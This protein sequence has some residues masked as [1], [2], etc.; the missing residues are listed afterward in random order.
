M[1]FGN[2]KEVECELDSIESIII[3][4]FLA[5]GSFS[6]LI[7]KNIINKILIIKNNL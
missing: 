3:Q 2:E 1:N 6:I 7:C 5:I 4:I